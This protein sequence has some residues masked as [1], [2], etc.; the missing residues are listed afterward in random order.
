LY[1]RFDKCNFEVMSVEHFVSKVDLNTAC[2]FYQVLALSQFEHTFLLTVTDF[3]L[4]SKS[5]FTLGSYD[6]V[7]TL[8]KCS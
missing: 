8:W 3:L 2:D 5:E 1:V 7:L 6:L 4:V